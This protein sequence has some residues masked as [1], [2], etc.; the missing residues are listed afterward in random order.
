LRIAYSS[1]R[2]LATLT[3]LAPRPNA[4]LLDL[5][6]GNGFLNVLNGAFGLV[7]LGDAEVG[8]LL[9]VDPVTCGGWNVL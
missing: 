4:H 6:A 5:T 9:C 2:Q 1:I 3:A 8:Y 7:A